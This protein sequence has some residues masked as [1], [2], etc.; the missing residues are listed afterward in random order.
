M[1]IKKINL[2]KGILIIYTVSNLI[3]L[4]GCSSHSD[5]NANQTQN[6]SDDITVIEDNNQNEKNNQQSENTTSESIEDIK[7]CDNF[8]S[9]DEVIN[10]FDELKNKVSDYL[11]SDNINKYK[12]K[13]YNIFLTSVGFITNQEPIR[14]VYF[15]DLTDETKQVIISA[16]DYIDEKIKSKFPTYKEDIKHFSGKTYDGIKEKYNSVKE[17]VK[18][19]LEEKLGI[20]KYNEYYSTYEEAKNNTKKIIKEGYESGKSKVKE[21]WNDLK[22]WYQDKK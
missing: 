19:K 15:N 16:S 8:N 9:E 5:K 10:Y 22:R 6:D 20:E 18:V 4:S 1:K 13:V 17:L 21:K 11:S 2:K 12:D 14:G 3:L 7:S